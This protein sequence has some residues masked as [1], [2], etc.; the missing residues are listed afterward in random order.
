MAEVPRSE[1]PNLS[2]LFEATGVTGSEVNRI[3]REQIDLAMRDT[4]NGMMPQLRARARW[5]ATTV[6]LALY[7]GGALVAAVLL[8]ITLAV[9]AWVAALIVGAILLIA[10]AIVYALA[11]SR[12]HPESSPVPGKLLSGEP[13]RPR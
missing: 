10:A 6:M 5:Y 12:T 13:H 11:K 8:L 7:G 4:V 2:P 3:L 1:G 9:P